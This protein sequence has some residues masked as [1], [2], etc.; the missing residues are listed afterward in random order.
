TSLNVGEL[1]AFLPTLEAA[2]AVSREG[3]TWVVDL[4]KVGVDRLL[5]GGALTR[6]WKVYVSHASKHAR[7]KVTVLEHPPGA[8]AAP[9]SSVP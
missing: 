7:E 3:E 1:D 4:A 9:P 2:G 5:G 8:A 6:T